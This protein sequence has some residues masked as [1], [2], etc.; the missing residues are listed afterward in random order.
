MSSYSRRR[1][2]QLS[3]SILLSKAQVGLGLLTAQ[4]MIWTRVV[5]SKSLLRGKSLKV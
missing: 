5:K 2:K 3:L 1:M 4:L